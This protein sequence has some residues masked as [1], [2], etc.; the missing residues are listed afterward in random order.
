M[1]YGLYPS[2]STNSLQLSDCES[3]HLRPSAD[4]LYSF[5]FDECPHQTAMVL[6]RNVLPFERLL[7]TNR[8]IQIVHHR[9]SATIFSKQRT[10]IMIFTLWFLAFS[11]SI[12]PNIG[13]GHYGFI[14]SRAT[15][16]IAFG[17]SYSYTTVLVLAFIATPFSVMVFCYVKIFLAVRRSRRRVVGRLSVGNLASAIPTES[18]ENLRKEVSM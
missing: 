10:K 14:S 9:D 13:W 11:I 6:R 7:H 1:R 16:F 17:S 15:C 5:R 18:K 2:S 3:Q 4:L 8:F 12:P